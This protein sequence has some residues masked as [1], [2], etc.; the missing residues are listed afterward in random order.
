M[1]K[2]IV[3]MLGLLTTLLVAGIGLTVPSFAGESNVAGVTASEVGAQ[4]VDNPVIEYLQFNTPF[5]VFQI[6]AQTP[7]TFL[8]VS[9]E[10]CCLA[11]DMWI[12]RTFCVQ[13]GAI[14]DVR[15]KALGNTT[16]FTASTTTY[17]HGE[18][19]MDCITEIR[20]GEGIAIFPAGMYVQFA[21]NK[22]QNVTTTIESTLVP[23]PSE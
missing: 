6:R 10:D 23:L 18:Q 9:L 5:D 15:G 3:I 14:W 2:F 13:N 11:G 1:K 17:K 21:T 12:Q 22:S 7:G 16:Y 8:T 19:P 4:T 20:Y